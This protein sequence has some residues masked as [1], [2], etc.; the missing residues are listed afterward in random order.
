[1][2]VAA[3]AATIIALVVFPTP[4]LVC[5]KE[6]LIIHSPSLQHNAIALQRS[7]ALALERFNATTLIPGE[8][9]FF[10]LLAYISIPSSRVLVSHCCWFC[11]SA[12]R[13][14]WPSW[15]ANASEKSCPP[16]R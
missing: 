12:W 1:P 5:T 9:V 3:A 10:R 15:A 4:P 16:I 6:T 2:A 14:G 11:W 8:G 13:R 7:S